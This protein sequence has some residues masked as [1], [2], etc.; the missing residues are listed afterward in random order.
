MLNSEKIIK[1][2]G[3]LLNV[4]EATITNEL[5]KI[6]LASLADIIDITQEKFTF[7]PINKWHPRAFS[8]IKKITIT[9]DVTG[10]EKIQLEF[11]DKLNALEKWLKILRIYP[12]V[13][14][15]M[16]SLRILGNDQ[17]LLDEQADGIVSELESMQERIKQ[18]LQ[19][20]REKE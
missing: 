4:N 3:D 12:D 20:L 13:L 18:R 5:A 2:I 19:S 6:A 7:K 17:F 15:T 10:G 1:Y 11:Y 16:Q 9:T 14:T 8:T